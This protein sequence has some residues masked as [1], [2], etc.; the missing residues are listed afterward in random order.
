MRGHVPVRPSAR[1]VAPSPARRSKRKAAERRVPTQERSKARL[2]R[3]LDAADAVF[4]EVGYAAATT[5]EIA[6]R[7]ETSIGSVYQFFPNKK[8]LFAALRTRYLV[9][10]RDLFEDLLTP[11]AI[12]RPW[13]ELLDDIVDAFWKFHSELPGFRAVWVHQS[14]ITAEMVEAGDRMNQVIAGRA[15]EVMAVVAPQIPAARRI[16]VASALVEMISALL[17]VAVRRSAGD[18]AK[19]VAETKVMARAYLEHV[20]TGKD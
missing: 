20:L 13:P 10:A 8:A 9:R 7:A 3:I 18:A 16:D 6:A 14:S 12:A 19:L 11:Q 5:E 17:L 2:E 1:K 4:A 15:A